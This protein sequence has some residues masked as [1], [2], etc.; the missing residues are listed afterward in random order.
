MPTLNYIVMP[1]DAGGMQVAGIVRNAV[2]MGTARGGGMLLDAYYH[3]FKDQYE[4]DA[5]RL[6]MKYATAAGYDG[7]TLIHV[8]ERIGGT[9]SEIESTGVSH[10]HA[11][12]KV[13]LERT[14]AVAKGL[15]L[16]AV[17]AAAT[18]K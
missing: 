8:L 1:Q 12:S 2:A 9:P 14:A 4:F 5:D 13:L 6:G 10:M 17:E 16:I 11:S 18:S 3:G 7:S 15:G